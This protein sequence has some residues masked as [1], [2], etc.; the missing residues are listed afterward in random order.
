MVRQHVRVPATVTGESNVT[1]TPS[2]WVNVGWFL[3]AVLGG[4][5]IA[6][7]GSW[8]F[9]V[10]IVWW[11]WKFAVI[12]CWQF[13][14]NEDT[15][16]IVERKGVFSVEIVEIQ[17]FRIKSI[18]VRKPF[19]IRLVGISIIDVI[20]SE[21]YRPYLCLYAIH[22]GKELT[23]FL[24]EMGDYWREKKGVRENDFHYF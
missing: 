6:E 2:Q 11:L 14:I 9:A 22:N 3:L 18:Q 17:Y 24:R 12:E 16:T 15:S 23:R 1:I 5:A 21:P 7:T 13:R 19:L 20:T 10:P 8:I 4:A